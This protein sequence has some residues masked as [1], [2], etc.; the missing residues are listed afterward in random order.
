M[1]VILHGIVNAFMHMIQKWNKPLACSCISVRMQTRERDRVQAHNNTRGAVESSRSTLP[2][3]LT[4]VLIH[5]AM[6]FLT[7]F[8]T[9]VYSFLLCLLLIFIILFWLPLFYF[10]TFTIVYNFV[11]NANNPILELISSYI[12]QRNDK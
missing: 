7:V 12:I 10:D 4:T 9:I 6:L 1:S 5:L 11:N 8:A 2:H 3:I